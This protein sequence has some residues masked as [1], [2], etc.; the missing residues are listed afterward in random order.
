MNSKRYQLANLDILDKVELS[1]SLQL[2]AMRLRLIAKDVCAY[3]VLIYP[4][5]SFPNLVWCT[6]ASRSVHVHSQGSLY[7]VGQS[8]CNK[9]RLWSQIFIPTPSTVLES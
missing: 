4:K 8:L 2:G 6:E 7:R 3:S 9:H 1:V 5:F